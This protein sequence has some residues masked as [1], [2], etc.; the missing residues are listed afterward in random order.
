MGRKKRRRKRKRRR[1]WRR[2]IRRK[3]RRRWRRRKGS[4]DHDLQ[5]ID[6]EITVRKPF[7]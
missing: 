1:R 2:R 4:G 3:I 6:N 7:N 5:K